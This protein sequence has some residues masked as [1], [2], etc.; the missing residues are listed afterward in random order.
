M[1]LKGAASA[2]QENTAPTSSSVQA[3]RVT[4]SYTTP[5]LPPAAVAHAALQATVNIVCDSKNG[6]IKAISGSGVIIDPRGVILTNAHIAQYV[7]LAS[8]S[9]F[10]VSCVVR[11]GSPAVN[12]WRVAPLFI[13]ASWVKK[14]AANII[15]TD[16][17]STGE[18]D[19]GLLLIT[20]SAG[21]PRPHSFPALPFDTREAIA[22]TDDSAIVTGYPAE[23]APQF[24]GH[25]TLYAAITPTTVGQLMTFDGGTVDMVSLG[26]V[27]AAQGGS[28]GGAVVNAWGFLVGIVTTTTDAPTTA[29]R[30]LR[31]ITLAH[32]DRN[33]RLFTGNSL[34]QFLERDTSAV[35][36]DFTRNTAP[37]LLSSYR[38]LLR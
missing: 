16:T 28:S 31:A 14:H 38:Q 6:S 8:D 34:A 5:P 1:I 7:L 2:R 33:M 19:F 37:D 35:A 11:I 3:E 18:Y 29:Q 22:F 21:L 25:H 30:D 23:F 24:S 13:P 15:D 10:G 27:P 26:G 20:A 4:Q 36:D 32:I 17:K 9:S 12:A